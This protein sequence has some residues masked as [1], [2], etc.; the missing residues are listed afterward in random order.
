MSSNKVLNLMAK[1]SFEYGKHTEPF[2]DE[3]LLL[4]LLF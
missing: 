4:L 3:P 2:M 1:I